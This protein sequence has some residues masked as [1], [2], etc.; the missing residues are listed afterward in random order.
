MQPH[1]SRDVCHTTFWVRQEPACNG[2]PISAYRLERDD[3]L[4]GDFVVD[5]NGPDRV[6]EAGGLVVSYC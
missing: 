1:A 2:D 3:G 4:D 6:H 5:Y